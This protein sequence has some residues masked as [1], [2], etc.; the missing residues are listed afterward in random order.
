LFNWAITTCTCRYQKKISESPGNVDNTHK[1]CSPNT[2]DTVYHEQNDTGNAKET[3]QNTRTS[4]RIC[5]RSKASDKYISAWHFNPGKKTTTDNDRC[6]EDC[7]P[8]H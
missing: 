1:K 8:V 5:I 6:N 4:E 7:D 2:P 3:M